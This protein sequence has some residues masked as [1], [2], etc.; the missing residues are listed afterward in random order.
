MIARGRIGTCRPVPA[1]PAASLSGPSPQHNTQETRPRDSAFRAAVVHGQL[2]GTL[3][4][5][6]DTNSH[7]Q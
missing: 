2:R 4:D 7:H 1:T 5:R 6:D 3:G